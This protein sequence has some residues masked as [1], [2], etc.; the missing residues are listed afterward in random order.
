MRRSPTRG[1]VKRTVERNAGDFANAGEKAI[2]ERALVSRN[3][4][5]PALGL[6]KVEAGRKAGDA[7]TVERARLKARGPLRGL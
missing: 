6:D 4:L 7:V 1:L 2:G 5:H 3:R